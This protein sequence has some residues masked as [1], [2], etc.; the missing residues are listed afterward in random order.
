MGSKA[1]RRPQHLASKLI[2]IRKAFGLSQTQVGQ[3]LGIDVHPGRISEYE[4]GLREPSLP[5]LLA[6]ARVARVHLEDL[7]DDE[8]SLPTC[9]PGNFDY[10][11]VS[12][13]RRLVP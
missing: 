6:Y 1:R 11:A 13:Q 12:R 4:L 5:T 10:I 3:H 9:L 2:Q 7:V 8:V